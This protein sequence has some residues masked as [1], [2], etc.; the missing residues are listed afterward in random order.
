MTESSISR[1][2]D[3]DAAYDLFMQ[4]GGSRETIRGL[5]EGMS[6]IMDRLDSG[7]TISST[8]ALIDDSQLTGSLVIDRVIEGNLVVDGLEHKLPARR[9]VVLSPGIVSSMVCERIQ[10]PK[11]MIL[12]PYYRKKLSEPTEAELLEIAQPEATQIFTDGTIRYL[13]KHIL[14][15]GL[16]YP[17]GNVPLASLFKYFMVDLLDQYGMG[18]ITK[19]RHK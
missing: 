14:N 10:V 16:T 9:V 5:C 17:Q 7:L 4:Q 11:V 6:I 15:K 8:G 3:F 1:L 13:R 12:N 2:S 18:N 19:Y